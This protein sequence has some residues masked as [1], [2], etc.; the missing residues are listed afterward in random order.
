MKVLTRVFNIIHDALILFFTWYQTRDGSRDLARMM[1]K[2]ESRDSIVTRLL[3]NGAIYFVVHLVLNIADAVL[4]VT[5]TFDDTSIF[6]AIFTPLILSHF[7]ISIRKAHRAN[8]DRLCSRWSEVSSLEFTP[9]SEYGHACGSVHAAE[10]LE[11]WDD[12]PSRSGSIVS[13]RC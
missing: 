3:L 9:F 1:E 10:D 4:T 8:E 12:I 5:G 13:P 7:F 11:D 2:L 6:N